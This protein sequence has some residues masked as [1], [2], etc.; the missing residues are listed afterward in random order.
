M[1]DL[2]GEWMA[3]RADWA[4]ANAAGQSVRVRNRKMDRL[5]ALNRQV[6]ERQDLHDAVSGLC[7]VDNTPETRVD[8]ALVREHWDIVGAAATFVSVIESSGA[9]IE[10]PVTMSRAL[11]VN[12][13]AAAR[14]AAL[15]LHN[16]DEGRGNTTPN[17]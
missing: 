2:M 3:A 6:A 1:A 13:T 16:I 7:E 14:T 15:C 12:T 8:A 5:R 9:S 17:L 11:S 4:A 10:R